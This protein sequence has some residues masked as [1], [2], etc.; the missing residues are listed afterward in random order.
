M[1]GVGGFIFFYWK[2]R[3]G[4]VGVDLSVGIRGI[5]LGSFVSL[6]FFK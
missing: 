2:G 3:D 5:I 6:M 4:E 1:G